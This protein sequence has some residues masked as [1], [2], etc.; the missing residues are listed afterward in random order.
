MPSVAED[1]RYIILFSHLVSAG[2]AG[3]G[4]TAIHHVAD[5]S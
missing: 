3:A 1:L 4:R 2:A 5:V